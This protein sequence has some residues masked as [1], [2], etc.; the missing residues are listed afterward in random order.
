[1][2]EYIVLKMLFMLK[3]SHSTVLFTYAVIWRIGMVL[4][5]FSYYI[6]ITQAF[7]TTWLCD[8]N[9][10]HWFPWKQQKVDCEKQINPN[11][12]P[13]DFLKHVSIHFL[14]DFPFYMVTSNSSWMDNY[15]TVLFNLSLQVTLFGI[16]FAWLFFF[17]LL[18]HTL[19]ILPPFNVS[20]SYNLVFGFYYAL[21]DVFSH[22]ALSVL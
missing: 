7:A 18:H 2:I 20:D 12:E 15:N 5:Y 8:L 17:L 1:M 10:V 13:V 22:S 16:S 9:D 21:N 6:N 11:N 4:V 3:R 19:R 14:S